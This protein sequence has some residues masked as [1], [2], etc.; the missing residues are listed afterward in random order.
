MLLIAS[1]PSSGPSR[2]AV[3][4]LHATLRLPHFVL[5]IFA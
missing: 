2:I 3:H 4:V 5:L 1:R